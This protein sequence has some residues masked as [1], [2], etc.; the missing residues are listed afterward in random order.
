MGKVISYRKAH[1]IFFRARILQQKRAQVIIFLEVSEL[2]VDR[3]RLELLERPSDEV[4]QRYGFDAKSEPF[5][6]N[7][8][9]AVVDR[10]SLRRH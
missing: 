10:G 4:S 8:R 3:I 6:R 7:A 5:R 2:E 9:S 1:E